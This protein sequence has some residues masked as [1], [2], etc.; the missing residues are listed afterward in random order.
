MIDHRFD[1]LCP[2]C[3]KRDVESPYPSYMRIAALAEAVQE[4]ARQRE[5]RASRQGSARGSEA[6][7][8]T[9]DG[10]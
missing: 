10:L 7:P 9:R 4:N 6:W 5:G 1:C 2:Y 8:A 3:L